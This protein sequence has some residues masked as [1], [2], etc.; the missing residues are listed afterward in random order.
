MTATPEPLRPSPAEDPNADLGFGSIAARESRR[1]LNRD[2]TFNVRREGLSFLQSHSAYHYFLTIPWSRLLLWI[3]CLYGAINTLFAA[4]YVGCGADA[5]TGFRPGEPV[6]LRFVDAFFFSVHTVATIGY[7]SIAP[8]N[9]AAN[10]IVSV[11]ALVGL[12]GFS[13]VAGIVYARFARPVA[14]IIFSKA[15][16]VGP[17]RGGTAF[18]FRIV[19]QRASELVE[20]EAKVMLARRRQDGASA[21]REFIN[22][23][24]ERDRVVFF[25]LS[26]TIVH[27]IDRESP[28]FGMGQ[29]DLEALEGEFLVLLNGFDETF[30]QIVH[31]RS[32]YQADEVLWG[33]RF[34]SMFNPPQS[35]GVVSVD[36]RKLDEVER[37]AL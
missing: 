28:L 22:L 21:D 29:Q 14:A 17:Y 15:A 2:G 9:M 7:G 33:A 31:T 35:D 34:R 32:S 26:W 12:I 10:I 3:G 8:H 13:L 5:L 23:K 19:N 36:I 18:M 20:L 4:A 27:P 6:E 16:I 1:L 30:N 25:P 24:L 11:E 37:V